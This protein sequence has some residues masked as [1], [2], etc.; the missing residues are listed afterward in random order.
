MS[1]KKA[2]LN[3]IRTQILDLLKSHPAGLSVYEL[4]EL[5]PDIGI[6][7]HLDRRVRDLRE[8]YKIQSR[9]REGGKD[10]IYVYQGKR[11]DAAVEEIGISGKLRAEVLHRAHGQCQMCGKTI[12]GD[13]VKLQID[14]KTPR[15][16]GGKSHADNLYQ[17]PEIVTR[18]V[19]AEATGI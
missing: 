2:S 14:H 7:Q 12:I 3:K 15:N 6:Q 17:V 11:T 1:G 10:I 16:W 5:I 13:A 8:H 4:R 9:R 18:T 19:L